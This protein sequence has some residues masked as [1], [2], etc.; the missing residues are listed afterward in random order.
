MSRDVISRVTSGQTCQKQ[1]VVLRVD[2]ADVGDYRRPD[3]HGIEFLRSGGPAY[4]AA[5]ARW[6]SLSQR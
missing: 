4:P 1:P 2:V 6:I 5:V 3:L